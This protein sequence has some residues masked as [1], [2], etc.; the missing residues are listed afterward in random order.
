MKMTTSTHNECVTHKN[1]AG[2]ADN[3][4][5]FCTESSCLAGVGMNV[6][7]PVFLLTRTLHT[8]RIIVG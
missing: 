2:L 4:D 5:L 8:Y 7:A 1:T 3:A 6:Q